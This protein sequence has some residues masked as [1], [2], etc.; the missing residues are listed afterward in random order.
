MLFLF[1]LYIFFFFSR[2]CERF[3]SHFL[4]PFVF[5]ISFSF[6]PIYLCFL[7][8]I[9]QV[10]RNR[11]NNVSFP[12]FLRFPI[13]EAASLSLCARICCISIFILHFFSRL[14]Q[15]YV[16]FPLAEF[17]FQNLTPFYSNLS[18]CLISSLI[19]NPSKRI[20]ATKSVRNL[21]ERVKGAILRAG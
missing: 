5:F 21:D 8:S 20:A 11:P 14:K 3:V 2:A 19:R 7:L 9:S 13:N 12:S 4:S 17:P 18:E 16:R 6:S 15:A 1:D 10:L